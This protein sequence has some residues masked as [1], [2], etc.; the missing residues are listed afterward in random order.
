MLQITPVKCDGKTCIRLIPEGDPPNKIWRRH[1]E[2][3]GG[4][5]GNARRSLTYPILY[6]LVEYVSGLCGSECA[7]V[8]IVGRM[9][10]VGRYKG[11]M[12]RLLSSTPT[13]G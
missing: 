13:G 7:I 10:P 5:G 4:R 3:L 8:N 6:K 9:P 1:P 2:R 11:R 12:A